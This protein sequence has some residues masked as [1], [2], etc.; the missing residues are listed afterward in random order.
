M[1]G[2]ALLVF[3]ALIVTGVGAI[4][5]GVA[6]WGW[7]QEKKAAAAALASKENSVPSEN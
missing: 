7:G 3:I 4:V 1:I 5:V 2:Y 6:I